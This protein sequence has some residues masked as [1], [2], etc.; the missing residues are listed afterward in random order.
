MQTSV[1]A[2]SRLLKHAG[3]MLLET[4]INFAAIPRALWAAFWRLPFSRSCLRSPCGGEQRRGL[5]PSVPNPFGEFVPLD[6]KRVPV[7]P[8]LQLI[9]YSAIASS[10][11]C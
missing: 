11:T 4:L 1:E 8:G 10:V 5:C 6:G 7:T 3:S 2:P 9:D